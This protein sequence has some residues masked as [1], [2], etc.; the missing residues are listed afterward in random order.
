[1]PIPEETP[2]MNDAGAQSPATPTFPKLAS[3]PQTLASL[4]DALGEPTEAFRRLLLRNHDEEALYE[5]GVSAES[6]NILAD[7]PRFVSSSLRILA[8]LEPGRQKLVKVPPSIF[9]LLVSEARTLETMRSGHQTVVTSEIG[10]RAD[11]E[12][13]LKRV[14]GEGVALRDNVLGSL[15][16]AMGSANLEKVRKAANDASAPDTLV[17]GLR[18]VASYIDDVVA[19]GTDDDRA[20]LE[21]FQ[22]GAE[23]AA[24]L[25]A[26][27]AQIDEAATVTAGTEKRVSQRTLDLQDGRVLVLMDMVY[28][29]FRHARRSDKALL[30]PELN[31]LSS[32][33]GATSSAPAAKAGDEPAEPTPGGASPA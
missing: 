31:R 8:A 11:R 28:R 20:A 25:R 13:T 5:W 23:A 2:E 18:A 29:A 21:A 12:A 17:K 1:M 22:T 15:R 3:G 6:G 14:S 32:V 4:A 26:K 33:F 10:G 24:E 16:N 7:V 30:L 19:N 9:A 27:A